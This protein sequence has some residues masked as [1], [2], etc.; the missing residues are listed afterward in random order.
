VGNND[1]KKGV[2]SL[3]HNFQT[4]GHPGQWQTFSLLSKDY[5][6]P[7]MKTDIQ[8]YIRGCTICQSTKPRTT[9]AKPPLDPITNNPDALPFEVITM[10]FIMKLPLSK[11]NDSILTITN[12]NCSKAAIFIPCKETIDAEGTAALYAWH[13]FPHFGILTK[14]ILDRDTRFTVKFTK[15][16]CRSLG[17]QQNISTAYHPRMDGASERTNQ[18]LEQYL[19]IYRNAQQDNWSKYLPLAQ[20]MHNSWPNQMT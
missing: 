19:H 20:S 3:Y 1:V 12:H 15:E 13:I 9:Q 6:W 16:L 2:I 7:N 14:I 5:W 17:I 11:G 8:D 10:D 4:A 18:W